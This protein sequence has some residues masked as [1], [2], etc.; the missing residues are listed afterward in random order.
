MDQHAHCA[1][2]G[3]V[4]TPKPLRNGQNYGKKNYIKKGL[5]K[6]TYTGL[7]IFDDL[8]VFLRYLLAGTLNSIT[9]SRRNSC[10]T[11][12]CFFYTS[13]RPSGRSM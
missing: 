8:K 6:V 1:G 9:T 5:M 13:S 3:V 2:F 4:K 11:R 10:A 12:S 7:R